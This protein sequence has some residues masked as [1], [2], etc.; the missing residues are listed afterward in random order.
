MQLRKWCCIEA[1]LFVSCESCILLLK[2]WFWRNWHEGAFTTNKGRHMMQYFA[3]ICF[4][5]FCY[6]AIF[7]LKSLSFSK[8]HRYSTNAPIIIAVFNK[9]TNNNCG[10]GTFIGGVPYGSLSPPASKSI[11]YQIDLHIF[12]SKC[13]QI[14]GIMVHKLSV[15]WGYGISLNCR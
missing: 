1:L 6:Y 12:E 9:C 13:L 7:T 14:H 8:M 3:S 15:I 11:F 5:I 10:I 4:S 2:Y